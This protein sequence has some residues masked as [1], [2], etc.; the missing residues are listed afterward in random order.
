MKK[1]KH[2]S[3]LA[4]VARGGWRTAPKKLASLWR[5]L[6]RLNRDHVKAI[7]NLFIITF[8]SVSVQ[9]YVPDINPLKSPLL[10]DIAIAVLFTI[11]AFMCVAVE[12][13]KLKRG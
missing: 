8:Y 4:V 1:P 5:Q 3:R 9:S 11:K 13:P 7:N 2:D 10:N 6:V 12:S